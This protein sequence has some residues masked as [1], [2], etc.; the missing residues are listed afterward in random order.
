MTYTVVWKPAA[1]R[2]LAEI[3][4]AATDRAEIAEAANE[5]DAILR[6]RP[7]SEGEARD[8]ATRI[9]FVG[10]LAVHYDVLEDDLRVDVVSVT[11][12]PKQ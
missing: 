7:R 3:W 6:A 5:I 1:E 11:L 8:G 4:N 10:S 12:I 9:L 2:R